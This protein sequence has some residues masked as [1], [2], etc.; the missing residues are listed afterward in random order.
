MC[1]HSPPACLH[2]S[3]TPACEVAGCIC[4][5]AFEG[6]M[7]AWRLLRNR[8][9]ALRLAAC[10]TT[11]GMVQLHGSRC[12]RN[13]VKA[14]FN[15]FESQNTLAET[16]KQLGNFRIRELAVGTGAQSCFNP[17]DGRAGASIICRQACTASEWHAA[18]RNHFDIL[19]TWQ[20]AKCE[21]TQDSPYAQWWLWVSLL[22]V[23]CVTLGTSPTGYK[24]H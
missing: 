14:L 20:F 5:I 9:R 3:E 11:S 21:S 6:A 7:S 23:A 1:L 12:T 10:E 22:I 2:A 8:V 16:Q 4:W 19:F 13:A 24:L 17:A 18:A 15:A